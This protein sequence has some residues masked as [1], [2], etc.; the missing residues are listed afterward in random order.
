MF[1]LLCILLALNLVLITG[2]ILIAKYFNEEIIALRKSVHSNAETIKKVCIEQHNLSEKRA[3][4]N[5]KTELESLYNHIEKELYKKNALLR[6]KIDS[7]ERVLER[8]NKETANFANELTSI[9]AKF[10]HLKIQNLDKV[11]TDLEKI[12]AKVGN[13]KL[14]TTSIKD[15]DMK[16][17]IM[18]I[19]VLSTAFNTYKENHNKVV[20]RINE[21]LGTVDNVMQGNKE[22]YNSIKELVK[23]ANAKVVEVGNIVNSKLTVKRNRS[24]NNKQNS[25]PVEG[26]AKK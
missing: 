15:E 2:I 16:Q 24:N 6:S 17:L 18:H 11:I 8:S 10:E 26:E 20:A 21:A 9:K 23:T 13:I 19:Q 7:F 14:P 22:H 4:K 1:E 25:K 5:L 12:S 3:F